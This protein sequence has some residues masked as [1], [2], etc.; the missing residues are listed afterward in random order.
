MPFLSSSPSPMLYSR[1]PLLMLC[2]RIFSTFVAA[3]GEQCALLKS[4]ADGMAAKGV[5]NCPR[6]FIPW[7]ISFYNLSIFGQLLS[8]QLVILRFSNRFFILVIPSFW[9]IRQTRCYVYSFYSLQHPARDEINFKQSSKIQLYISANAL[10]IP[11][12]FIGLS[13]PPILQH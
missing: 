6:D 8:F 12:H 7:G 10:W 9:F 1:L 5:V 2:A 3:A 11:R 13:Y 4:N